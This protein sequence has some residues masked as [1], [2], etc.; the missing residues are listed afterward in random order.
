MVR[1]LG[2]VAITGASGFI[3]RHLVAELRQLREG[4]IKILS[5]RQQRISDPLECCPDVGAIQGDLHVPDSLLGFLEPGCTVVHL[6]Y[7]YGAGESK[8]LA[9]TANLLAACKAANARRLIHCSTAAVVGRAPDNLVTEKTPCKPVS[10][11][12]ITKFKIEEAIAAAASKDFDVVILRPTSVFGPE[13]DPMR[14]LVRDLTTRNSFFNYL[15]S[16]LF[17]K[18]RMNLVHVSNVVA[19]IV[20]AIRRE[21]A[22]NGGVFIVS[23]DDGASNN[24]SDVEKLLMHQLGVRN[25]PVPTVAVSLELLS[26]LLKLLG[27]NNVNP[28]CN[29]EPRKLL[30][31]G[32][33]RP[34]KFE[35]GLK[36][37]AD[38]YCSVTRS[39]AKPV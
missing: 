21:E 14:K 4:R 39:G 9:A 7:L 6:A 2:T 18:R 23:D 34:T 36:G 37:Y 13:G 38:W 35:D 31:L 1:P 32:F 33:E 12:G 27:R 20:F 26:L 25:Y 8:N 19:A 11:Y 22:F 5:R 10:E 24:F 16:C 28:C 30:N 15:K 29:Y 17:N 3:G